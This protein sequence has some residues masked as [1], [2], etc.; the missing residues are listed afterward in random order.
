MTINNDGDVRQSLIGATGHHARVVLCTVTDKEFPVAY[1]V[2]EQL[3]PMAEVNATGAHTFASCL[4]MRELPFVLVQFPFRANLFA[5]KDVERWVNRFRPQHFL[6]T[7]TTGGVH[8]PVNDNADVYEFEGP[9][10]GDILVSEYVHYSPFMKVASTE[11]LPRGMPMDQPSIELVRHAR[12]VIQDGSWIDLSRTFRSENDADPVA[13]FVEIVSGEAI[14]DDPLE[15]MQQFLMK[16]FD[17]AGAI[18]ME[19]AGVAQSLYAARESVHYSPGFIT[20]RG[21][22][23]I[24]YARGRKRELTQSDLPPVTAEKTSERGRWSAPAAATA[25]AFAVALTAR[26]VKGDQDPQ[27]GHRKIAGYPMPQLPGLSDPTDS[28]G[29]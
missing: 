24:V 8:R 2:L 4:S 12:A 26:L 1:N 6:V 7:G 18:E 22:S 3:G 9:A 21:V 15:P 19:S 5:A 14:Q 27:P 13:K 16:H 28:L 23:D 20:I 10:W 25:A 17:R 29:S 11:Y